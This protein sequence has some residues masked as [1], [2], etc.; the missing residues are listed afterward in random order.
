MARN[1]RKVA[2]KPHKP[3]RTNVAPFVI[4]AWRDHYAV[5]DPSWVSHDAIPA[6]L[7]DEDSHS[8]VLTGGWIVGED[9]DRVVIAQSLDISNDTSSDQMVVYKK[10]I[11]KQ[12]KFGELPL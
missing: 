10:L 9:N 8:I 7:G 5:H 11:V 12:W 4:V 6:L 3:N 2:H 1:D